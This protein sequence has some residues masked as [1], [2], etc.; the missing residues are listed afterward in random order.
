MIIREEFKPFVTD[1]FVS[2]DITSS[3]VPI[4]IFRDTQFGAAQSLLLKG[5]I[6]LSVRNSTS[7][8]YRLRY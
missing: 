7:E 3:Q 2:Q 5:V 8:C 6:P 4:M 1:G